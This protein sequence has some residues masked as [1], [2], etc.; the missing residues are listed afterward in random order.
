[1]IKRVKFILDGIM[2]RHV[3]QM[4]NAKKTAKDF[5]SQRS[6]KIKSSGLGRNLVSR[7]KFCFKIFR[8]DL[9]VLEIC[10]SMMFQ[11]M[12]H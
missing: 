3:S 4:C 1:V 6:T 11:C 7:L 5:P 10:P 12:R 9:Y 2:P 8:N